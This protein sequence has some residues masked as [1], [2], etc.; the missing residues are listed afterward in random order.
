MGWMSGIVLYCSIWAVVF[1]MV[2]PLGIVSQ[3]ES[4]NVEPG[5]PAS[6]PTEAMIARKMLITS[7]IA[8]VLFAAVWSV[9]YFHLFTLD[10]IPFLTP[11]SGR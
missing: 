5:T 7:A 2:L 6:A 4:G 1:F 11:P 10:D 8:T 3:Q 9:I